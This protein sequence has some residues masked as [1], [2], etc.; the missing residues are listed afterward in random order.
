MRI[1]STY[2][3]LFLLMLTLY[4]TGE[5]E[6]QFRKKKKKEE[7]KTEVIKG[8]NG[9][10]ISARY[11]YEEEF[12][13][14]VGLYVI[15]DYEEAL[16][17][18]KDLEKK[19]PTNDVVKYQIALCL[20]E[21]NAFDEA[22]HKVVQALK[23][24]EG[25]PYYYDFLKELFKEQEKWGEVLQVL[26]DKHR[27][28]GEDKEVYMEKA[29]C[30][31]MLSKPY[32]A[33][34]QYDLVE[35]KFGVD[36]VVIHQKQRIYF[37]LDDFDKVLEEGEKLITTYPHIAAYRLAQVRILLGHQQNDKAMELLK[38]LVQEHPEDGNVQ[39]LLGYIYRGQGN[40]EGFLE[41]I[42]KA[43]QSEDLDIN[44][45]TSLLSKYLASPTEAQLDEGFRFAELAL[46]AT[47]DSYSLNAIM[48]S[49]LA[50]KKQWKEAQVYYE[51][52]VKLNPDNFE[53]WSELLHIDQNIRDV[54]KLLYHSEE[55]MEIF[56]NNLSFYLF[57][58]QANMMEENYLEASLILE[59]AKRLAVTPEAKGQLNA[60]LAEVYYHMK[61]YA[62]SDAY[63]EEALRYTPEAPLVLN[64]YSYFLS[65][66]KEYLSK[67]KA[68]AE[69]LVELYP[70]N[71]SYIDTY[72]WVLYAAED[73][74][75][76]EKFLA[77]AIAI[78]EE[79]VI[80]EHYGDVL[81]KLGQKDKALIYWKKAM[82]RG[83]DANE[84]LREKVEQGKLVE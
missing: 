57:N 33:L 6:A 22:E 19:D 29:S 38:P 77:K 56:P 16:K 59:Q 45:K 26:E 51:Q 32:K 17:I 62:K 15:Q 13:G 10:T 80:L 42:E 21:M 14:A 83:G 8:P 12:I 31:L 47:P 7:K 49:F 66:R 60:Q 53:V 30:Y 78:S 44:E 73:Y 70:G 2:C 50:R 35:K 34:E 48:G 84:Q 24:Q 52:S 23:L 43:I 41:A 27:K 63:F 76:A 54:K 68:M 1:D 39:F 28:L 81:F 65:L 25:N 61:D 71:P 64:N 37:R 58:G 20:K 75:N 69:K 3:I 40:Q 11:Q 9:P 55:A 18:F 36:E 79:A 74:E 72:A 82:E 5:V 4:P 46:Q 67:A